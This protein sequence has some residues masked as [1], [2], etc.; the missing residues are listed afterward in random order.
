KRAV[1]KSSSEARCIQ[2]QLRRAGLWVGNAGV[3]GLLNVARRPHTPT[4]PQRQRRQ[5]RDGGVTGGLNLRGSATIFRL[6]KRRLGGLS[7][8]SP[9][10]AV[11]RR[12]R[13]TGAPDPPRRRA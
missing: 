5:R 13:R 6:Q 8:D 12:F 7:T 11:L 1:K 10:R 4:G 2:A 3:S 9:G